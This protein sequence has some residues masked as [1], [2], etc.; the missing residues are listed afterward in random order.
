MNK[1]SCYWGNNNWPGS[2]A[3]DRG[4]YEL[5]GGSNIFGVL[6]SSP[7]SRSI[8]SWERLADSLEDQLDEIFE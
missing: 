4:L 8:F 1:L 3:N 7:I 2:G 5:C 6:F